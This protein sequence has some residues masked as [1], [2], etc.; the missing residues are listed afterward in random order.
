[1]IISVYFCNIMFGILTWITVDATLKVVGFDAI[2][3]IF[4]SLPYPIKLDD[5]FVGVC[6]SDCTP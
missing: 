2:D 5:I 1:M 3:A 6:V 4:P